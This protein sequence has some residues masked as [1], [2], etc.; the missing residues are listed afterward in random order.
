MGFPQPSKLGHLIRLSNMEI[1]YLYELLPDTEVL[2]AL[3][4]EELAGYILQ[5]LNSLPKNGTMS[6]ILNRYNYSL[7]SY[8]TSYPEE[9]I[10]DIVEA[11]MEAWIWL[12]REGLIAP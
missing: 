10:G 3:E 11:V 7:R 12:E 8:F 2:L 6:S 5:H 9:K 4:P 1:N